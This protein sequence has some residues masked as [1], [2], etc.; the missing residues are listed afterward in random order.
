MA[1]RWVVGEKQIGHASDS[2]LQ[3][4]HRSSNILK[5]MQQYLLAVFTPP[6]TLDWTQVRV[7][8]RLLNCYVT[9]AMLGRNSTGAIKMQGEG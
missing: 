3:N 4:G 7:G 6:D 2:Q 5:A 1:S 8:F 9:R